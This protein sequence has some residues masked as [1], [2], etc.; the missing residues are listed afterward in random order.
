MA[1]V[2]RLYKDLSSFL[3]EPCKG[4]KDCKST[5]EICLMVV[6]L[7]MKLKEVIMLKKGG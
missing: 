2:D 7:K 3:R 4:C 6:E 5:N 1:D